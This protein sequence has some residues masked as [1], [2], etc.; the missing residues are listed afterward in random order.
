MEKFVEDADYLREHPTKQKEDSW[1]M[2][3]GDSDYYTPRTKTQL[4][5]ED[6]DCLRIQTAWISLLRTQ[7]T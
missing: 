7:T 3:V 1:D 5:V 6:S 2:F 4:F